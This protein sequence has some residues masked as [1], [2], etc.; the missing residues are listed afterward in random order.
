MIPKKRNERTPKSLS[1]RIPSD[2]NAL[3][4]VEDFAGAVWEKAVGPRVKSERGRLQEHFVKLALHEACLNIMR[5]AYNNDPSKEI[6]IESRIFGD[7]VEFYIKDK[8]KRFNYITGA[9]LGFTEVP[10]ESGYGLPLITALMDKIN[11]HSGRL[12]GNVFKLTKR[13]I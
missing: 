7:K 2:V 5:H 10:K 1:L 11:Y 4:K 9:G 8:G 3:E 12:K 13:F 6:K